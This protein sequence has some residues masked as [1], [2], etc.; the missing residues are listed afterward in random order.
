[1]A[2]KRDLVVGAFVLAGTLATV[3]VVF[4]IGSERRVFDKKV[5]LSATFKDVQG[6]KSGAPIRLSGVDIGTVTSVAHSSD[7]NDDKLYVRMQIVASEATRVREDSVATVASKGLL[8]DKM[9]EITPG[10]PGK[11]ALPSGATVNS[12]E[13]ADYSQLLGEVGGMAKKADDILANVEKTTAV[14]ANE[15]TQKDVQQTLH[16]VTVILNTVA[17]GNG[18]VSRLLNDPAEADRLSHTLASFQQTA[19]KLNQ[20]LDNSNELMGRVK[21]GPGFAHDMI[22]DDGASKTVAQFG[23]AADELAQTLRGVRTG[24]GFAHGVLYGGDPNQQQMMANLDAMSGDLRDIV[25]N[26][27]QGK[28]TIGALLVDPSIYEDMKSVLGNVERNDTL[29]ALVRYSIKQDEKKPVVDVSGPPAAP[30]AKPTKT[31]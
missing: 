27:K 18:Y 29:R 15:Q 4:M 2:S 24:N 3:G 20:T 1:M 25:H 11:R 22:Y 9:L 31:E 21:S 10:T 28:G 23:G 30:P 14:L 19:A 13:P 6:L 17:T 12:E 26:V 7:P 16:S 5:E 8:G